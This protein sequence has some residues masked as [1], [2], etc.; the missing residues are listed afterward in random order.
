MSELYL[1]RA[2]YSDDC[3][4][5]CYEFVGVFDDEDEVEKAQKL[6][7]PHDKGCFEWDLRVIKVN[8]VIP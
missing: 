2:I 1:L 7:R 8:E 6:Y 4:Y 5:C 3:T